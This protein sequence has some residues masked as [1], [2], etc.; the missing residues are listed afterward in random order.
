MTSKQE[1]RDEIAELNES[2]LAWRE[3]AYAAA[4][5]RDRL[6]VDIAEVRTERD[7]AVRERDLARHEVAALVSERN[8]ALDRL[9]AAQGTIRDLTAPEPAQV[10]PFRVG[11]RVRVAEGATWRAG[12]TRP[13]SAMGGRSGVVWHVYGD[14][15]VS[16]RALDG[17]GCDAVSPEFCTLIVDEPEPTPEPNVEAPP[18]T[19]CRAVANLRGEHLACDIKRPHDVH[20]NISAGLIWAETGEPSS[21]ETPRSE[22]SHPAVVVT[23]H[24]G[25][26]ARYEGCEQIDFG[27]DNS[28]GIVDDANRTRAVV[29]GART[30]EV[31]R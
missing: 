30:I 12:D 31:I 17:E 5:Q 25:T 10:R 14:E 3:E 6:K 8:D 19:T 29:F 22:W 16:V 23:W 1:L 4:S 15:D 21:F 18:A 2:R 20:G 7:R 28:F 26:I 9:A 27:A 24:D 13:H 11:D